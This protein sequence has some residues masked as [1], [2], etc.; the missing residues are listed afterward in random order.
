MIQTPRLVS[1]SNSAVTMQSARLMTQ[2]DS[3][4]RDDPVTLLY[5]YAKFFACGP[6]TLRCHSAGF[7]ARDPVELHYSDESLLAFL[8]RKQT[9]QNKQ[10]TWC[11]EAAES[12]Q[13]VFTP[14][15]RAH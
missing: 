6:V 12:V 5:H 9:M 10:K 2:S 3:T 13:G 15:T 7:P 1:Q 11:K 14:D 4:D 8:K